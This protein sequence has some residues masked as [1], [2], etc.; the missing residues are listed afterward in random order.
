MKKEAPYPSIS[1]FSARLSLEEQKEIFDRFNEP[2]L[3]RKAPNKI[4]GFQCI[5]FRKIPFQE[6]GRDRER[7]FGSLEEAT[8][9]IRDL[10]KK[11]CKSLKTEGE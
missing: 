1:V 11:Y 6:S 2:V 8:E 10:E 7:L 9:Y 4:E 5:D 3:G